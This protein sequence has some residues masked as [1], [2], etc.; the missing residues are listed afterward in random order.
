M[1]AGRGESQ[2]LRALPEVCLR[3]TVLHHC[4]SNSATRVLRMQTTISHGKKE[5]FKKGVTRSIIAR[6]MAERRA[7]PDR[8]RRDRVPCSK[9]C[10]P[11]E[12]KRK[13]ITSTELHIA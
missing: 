9:A 2:L 12:L 5:R 3:R 11:S 6:G 4:V 8:R 1:R 13:K 7:T 10:V